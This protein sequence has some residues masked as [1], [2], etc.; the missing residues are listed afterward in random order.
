MGGRTAQRTRG[1]RGAARRAAGAAHGRSRA[2]RSFIDGVVDRLPGPLGGIIRRARE[3]DV[4]LVSAGL[5]FYALVTIPPIVILAL[6]VAGLV[7]GEDNVDRLAQQ[8]GR[9]GPEGLG[10]DRAV[11]QVSEQGTSLGLF[12]VAVALWPASAYGS[13]LVRAFERLAVG[14]RSRDRTPLLG[15]LLMLT[16]VMPLFV[17]GSI[18]AAFAGAAVLDDGALGRFL[19]LALGLIAGFV[20]A[21]LAVALIYRIFPPERLTWRQIARGTVVAA[22][23]IAVLSSGLV[24]FVNLGANFRDHYVSS[25]LAAVVLT[26]VW[27]FLSNALLL[28]GYKSAQE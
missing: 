24:L 8:I 5:G 19:G 27:L 12:A 23:G 9:L 7:A 28:V 2:A 25:G 16:V 13:G 18:L 10:I 21:S 17:L 15:R 26:A 11:H 20:G 3:D 22:V 6:W 1:V 4:L 14:R